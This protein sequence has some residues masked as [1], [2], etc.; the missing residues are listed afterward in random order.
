MEFREGMRQRTRK[1]EAEDRGMVMWMSTNA[2]SAI[3]QLHV[4]KPTTI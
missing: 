3:A 2:L 4:S 1:R